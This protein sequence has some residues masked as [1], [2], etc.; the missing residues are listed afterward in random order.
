[1]PRGGEA[2][3]ALCI[4]IAEPKP[5]D[6]EGKAKGNWDSNDGVD[7]AEFD[8]F[9]NGLGDRADAVAEDFFFPFCE[10]R[11]VQCEQGEENQG[12]YWDFDSG[13]HEVGGLGFR[14]GGVLEKVEPCPASERAELI[15]D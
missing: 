9:D 7:E 11:D 1:M 6:N 13:S 3:A 15:D 14:L 8:A 10:P 2:G 5:G 12:E 4:N